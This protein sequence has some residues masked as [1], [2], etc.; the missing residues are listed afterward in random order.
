M[1]RVQEHKGSA[2]VL[3]DEPLILLE[4]EQMLRA[5]GWHV[6]HMSSDIDRALEL[7]RGEAFD[8]AI[9]DINV[10]GRTSFEVAHI[11]H[12]RKV[13]TILAT[14]Y[15]TELVAANC[16]EVVFL[17][18]PYLQRDLAVALSQALDEP[19]MNRKRA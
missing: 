15:S 1:R 10:R 12:E 14:G 13:P 2:F 4:L 18:K 6:A 3:E 11:L 7:A 5:L 19:S 16:A 9:L 8:V 17:Q